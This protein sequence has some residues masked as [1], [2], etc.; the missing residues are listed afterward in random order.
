MLRS[1]SYADFVWSL[2][3]EPKS[4]GRSYAIWLVMECK[5]IGESGGH[6][7]ERERER[8]RNGEI[9]NSFSGA[10]LNYVAG[11]CS[12]SG[13]GPSVKAPSQSVTSGS[14]AN[15]VPTLWTPQTK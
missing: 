4:D 3:I 2:V 14:T 7:R 8:E 1:Y 15:M 10:S 5:D 11:Y 13:E 6:R 9:L 12:L